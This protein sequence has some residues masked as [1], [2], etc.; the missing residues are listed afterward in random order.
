MHVA[1]LILLLIPLILFGLSQALIIAGSTTKN[2]ILEYYGRSSASFI[3]LIL[4]AIYGTIASACLNVFGYGGLGQWTTAKAFKYSMLWFT[5]VWFEIEDEKDWLNTT[6]PAVFVGNH[7]TE[8]DVAFL[9][10]VFPKYCS[11]TAKKSLKKVPFLGWFMALSKTVFIERSSRTQAVAA[12]DKAAEQ[13]HSNKQSVYIF[14]EG[15]RSYYDYPDMLSFKKGAF[16]LAVQAQ[17]PIVPVVV[18]NYSNVLN[19]KKKIFRAGTIP[20]RALEPI[21]TKGK[22]KDDVDALLQETREKML[23]A[24]REITESAREKGVAVQQ[25]E[26]TKMVD[27]PAKSTGVDTGV[28]AAA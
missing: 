27:G 21:S 7:Q 25:P 13:M 16:H 22:T 19:V 1:L 5:G 18:A 28:N 15:T 2:N 24:L 4:C 12:F 26:G 23:S 10:H 14:P 17:V 8:L 20:A 9:G 11:V 3:A 6:R